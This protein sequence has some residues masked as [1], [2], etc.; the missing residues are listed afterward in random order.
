MKWRKSQDASRISL[1]R[2]VG[3][4]NST[5]SAER[6]MNN[7]TT[8]RD[9]PSA[10]AS[11]TDADQSNS[12][13]EERTTLIEALDVGGRDYPVFINSFWTARQRQASSLHEISYRACFKA[14]LPRFFIDLLTADGDTVYDPFAGRGTTAVEAALHRRN[15]VANDIS[16]LSAIL[17]W[18]RIHPPSLS[19]VMERLDTIPMVE[20]LE[21]DID[22]TMF[23][24]RRTLCE[25]LSLREYLRERRLNNDEDA[26]D[27]WIRMVATNRLTGHSKGFF[28]V[29]SLPPNQAMSADKQRKINL[30]R[31]QTP[32]YRDTRDVILKKSRSL[33]K[34]VTGRQLENLRAVAPAAVFLTGDARSTPG[35]RGSSV[36]LTVTSPPFLDVVQ[37][38]D[39]NWLRCW[40]NHLDASEIDRSLTMC[41]RLEDWCAVMREVFHEL[42]RITRPGG[43]VAFEV[44]EVRGGKVRLEEYVVPCGLAAGF[45]CIGI[46]VNRQSF[47]K[48][49]HIWGIDNNRKGTNTNRIALFAK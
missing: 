10:L 7:P 47:T 45:N 32:E 23:F 15:V 46:M 48:T 14:H 42:Y 33:L 49:A 22:L 29:Y 38:A 8:Y 28:S 25:I 44:G 24:H 27:R 37:Y 12:L 31:N 16:P 30:Q 36:H 17:A 43:F 18:P 35:I 4:I 5:Y 20:E 21:A 40:F 34:N 13:F 41:R 26:V 9:I 6:V 3:R 39:D 19:E 2:N 11:C 1:F